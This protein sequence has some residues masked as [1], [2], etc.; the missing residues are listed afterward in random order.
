MIGRVYGSHSANFFGALDGPCLPPPAG[1]RRRSTRKRARSRPAVRRRARFRSYATSPTGTPAL[2]VTTLRF[3]M[4]TVPS[5][6]ASTLDCSAPPLGGAADVERTHGELRAGFADGLRGNDANGFT[7]VHRRATG[8]IA[9]VAAG[10]D[11]DL[12]FRR[13][14]PSGFS[15]PR[16]R[17]A[18]PAPPR[19]SSTS[20]LRGRRT[21]LVAGSSTSSD[22]VRP[23][24]RSEREETMS[25]PSIT[26][27]TVRP[28]SEPQSIST[29]MQSCATSTR[30][31]VR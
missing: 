28:R 14:A 30:R 31:R 8:E 27:R 29:M 13:S 4:V 3:L 17:R 2:L 21:L 19:F 11:A 1:A 24:I 5:C 18:P 10:A 15:S 23:R 20:V 16:R 6:D 7:D 22:V 9:P 12:A 25:P 26:G